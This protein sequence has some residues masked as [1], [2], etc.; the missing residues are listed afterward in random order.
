V[1]NGGIPAHS[2]G[3]LDGP[4]TNCTMSIHSHL[5]FPQSSSAIAS[6]FVT[7]SDSM[8]NFN[9]GTCNGFVGRIVAGAPCLL[10]PRGAAPGLSICMCGAAGG[11]LAA[12]A[13][14][15]PPVVARAILAEQR[16][17]ARSY[18]RYY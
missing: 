2:E 17:Y 7:K 15:A 12:A 4:R 9:L 13:G 6:I 8:F 3:I 10:L 5:I 16:L 18:L 1:V 14:A 11:P